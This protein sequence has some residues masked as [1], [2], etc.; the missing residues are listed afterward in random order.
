MSDPFSTKAY[1]V[2]EPNQL[3][4]L[5]ASYCQY[6]ANSLDPN[7]Q[8]KQK[9]SHLLVKGESWKHWTSWTSPSKPALKWK[10]M[11]CHQP[12]GGLHSTLEKR[13][14]NMLLTDE[15]IY[16]L[17][18]WKIHQEDL[19]EIRRKLFPLKYVSISVSEQENL[20]QRMRWLDGI[21]NSMD[22]SFNKLQKLVIN[23]E[24]W[25][26][27]VYEVTESDTTEWLNWTEYRLNE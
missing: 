26:A 20:W 11:Q 2:S 12:T 8:R 6:W 16:V 22:M 27:A 25:R 15:N 5:R 17:F 1:S 21:T 23:R 19:P 13:E 9:H 14:E 4:P 24:A 7:W 3:I 18:V 10:Q